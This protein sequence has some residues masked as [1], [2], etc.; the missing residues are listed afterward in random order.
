ETDMKI[1]CRKNKHRNIY[2][3]LLGV[4]HNLRSYLRAT[5]LSIIKLFR[6]NPCSMEEIIYLFITF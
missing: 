1:R 2:L 5:A 6:T 4:K 3:G